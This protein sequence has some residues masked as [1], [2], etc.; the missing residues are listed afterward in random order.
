[1][2]TFVHNVS[3]LCSLERKKKATRGKPNWTQSV[4]PDWK[5]IRSKEQ[6]REAESKSKRTPKKKQSP[7]AKPTLSKDEEAAEKVN[8]VSM[9]AADDPFKPL[10]ASEDDLQAYANRLK[11]K[12]SIEFNN[13]GDAL[14]AYK[15]MMKFL[16]AR[17]R[18]GSAFL[19]G[20]LQIAAWSMSAFYQLL[21]IRA[22]EKFVLT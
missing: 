6:Q 18:V 4:H 11:E 19:G 1:M 12:F 7:K 5:A 10:R 14:Q 22:H 15:D 2:L 8:E 16:E 13:P 21:C 17:L 20:Q 3:S 9:E